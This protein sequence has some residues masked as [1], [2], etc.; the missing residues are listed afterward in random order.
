MHFSNKTFPSR[1]LAPEPRSLWL[2]RTGCLEFCTLNSVA[3]LTLKS[4]GDSNEHDVLVF[5][6]FLAEV[7][8]AHSGDSAG[9]KRELDSK[10]KYGILNLVFKVIFL[11]CTCIDVWINPVR[12]YSISWAGNRTWA[13]SKK[14]TSLWL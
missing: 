9:E 14:P 12:H 5:S 7:T 11:H 8:G 10:K 1:N 6:R 3:W 4:S 13:M 2:R